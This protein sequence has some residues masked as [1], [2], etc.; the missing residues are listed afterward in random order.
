MLMV[1]VRGV[2]LGI[3]RGVPVTQQ[4]QLAASAFSMLPSSAHT[5]AKCHEAHVPMLLCVQLL[6]W[7]CVAAHLPSISDDRT[8][9]PWLLLPW[10]ALLPLAVRLS[11][12]LFHWPFYRQHCAMVAGLAQFLSNI[13]SISTLHSVAEGALLPLLD[14]A[15]R[16][17]LMAFVPLL[18]V[19]RGSAA[20]HMGCHSHGIAT[21]NSVFDSPG[22][23][24]SCSLSTSAPRPCSAPCHTRCASRFLPRRS[25]S[26]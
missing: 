4:G 17:R 18:A 24:F 2:L 22:C 19:S 11:L 12:M 6:M 10:L 9:Q 8:Q 25:C 3:G 13:T 23:G 21:V 1:N 5:T 16:G 15:A 7:T 20:A 26:A 14:P